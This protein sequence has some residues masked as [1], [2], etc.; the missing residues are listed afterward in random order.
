MPGKLIPF[1]LVIQLG[2]SFFSL[3]NCLLSSSF[4]RDNNNKTMT[5]IV[6]G[7]QF[8]WETIFVVVII[9]WKDL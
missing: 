4:P 1:A 7:K 8:C 5:V 3:M 6:V 2:L 9:C